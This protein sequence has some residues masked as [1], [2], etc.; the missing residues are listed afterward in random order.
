[1]KTRIY[2]IRHGESHQNAEDLLSGSSDVKLSAAGK[3]QCLALRDFFNN[4]PVESVFSSRLSRAKESARLI[5]PNHDAIVLQ[6]MREINYGTY[7][8]YRR[9]LYKNNEDEI[10]RQWTEAPSGLVFPE[11]DSIQ[12]HAKNTLIGFKELAIAHK[13]R[14][15][16]CVS[17]RTTIRLLVSSIL[18]L[19]L[20]YF[21]RVPCSNC[22]IT[23]VNM[24]EWNELSVESINII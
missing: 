20:N 2:I 9:D 12:E 13:G 10:I 11:G 16:A 4:I 14:T 3:R 21:R 24:D 19:D 5:F 15:I 8:G 7:E 22:G 23:V 1:M 18:G 6:F 17:H